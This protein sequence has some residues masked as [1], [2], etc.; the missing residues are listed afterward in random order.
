VKIDSRATHGTGCAFASAL[1]CN[2]AFKKSL[3][4]AVRAAKQFVAD[5]IAHAYHL[6]QGHGPMNHLFKLDEK[7]VR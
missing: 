2:L 3:P 1:A 5:A 4:E 7:Q 6:G